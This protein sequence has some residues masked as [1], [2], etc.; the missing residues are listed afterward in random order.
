MARLRAMFLM[1]LWFASIGLLG[2]FA[3]LLR[4]ITGSESCIF[5]PTRVVVRLGL[6]L[7]GV[8]VRVVGAENLIRRQNYL[9]TPNH[10][11]F[12]EVPMLLTYL[13]RNLGYLAKKEL[14]KYPVFGWGLRMVGVIPVDRQDSKAAVDSARAAAE[15]MRGGKKDYV[16]Y[17]EGTRSPDGR[18]LPF[19]K[20]AFL[21]ALDAGVPLVPVSIAGSNRVMP[22]GEARVYPARITITVHQPIPIEAYSRDNVQDLMDRTRERI[23]SAL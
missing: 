5:V 21:M 3:I 13:R 20:G 11:S 7:V 9:F 18:L 10:Q 15:R 19:K 17:P 23:Q 14:F 12:I 4:I 16:V 22:K 1:S 8:R 2:P 6:A